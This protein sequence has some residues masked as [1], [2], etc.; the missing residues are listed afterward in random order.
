MKKIIITLIS[1]F[2]FS[3]LSFAADSAK[4]LMKEV[5][6]QFSAATKYS[7]YTTK[8]KLKVDEINQVKELRKNAELSLKAGNEDEAHKLLEEALTILK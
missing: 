5:D 7:V 4:N 6:K 3:T 1:F 2:M 8:K